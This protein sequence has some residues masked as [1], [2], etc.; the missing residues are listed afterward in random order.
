M[1]QFNDIN[2]KHWKEYGDI[3]TD[4]LWLFDKRDNSGVHS[5]G[6]H[7]N[8][9]PQIPN[10]LFRRYT[11]KGDWILDPFTG[12]GTSLI[13]AQRLGRNSLG[14][15]L[16]KDVAEKAQDLLLEEN[17]PE[18]KGKIIVGDSRTVNLHSKL[19]PFGIDKVQFIIYHPPY[20]DIVKFSDNPYDLSNAESLDVFLNSLGQ[21]IDN[22]APYLEKN[23]Y[24]AIVIGDKYS[25]GEIAPLGFYCMNLFMQRDFILKAILVKNFEETKG[26]TNQRAIWRYRALSS[27][28]Y[29][30]KH[31]YIMVFKKTTESEL[32]ISEEPSA[33][34][35]NNKKAVLFYNGLPLAFSDYTL[36]CIGSGYIALCEKADRACVLCRIL[37]EKELPFHKGACHRLITQEQNYEPKEQQVVIIK[38]DLY[39]LDEATE[40][41]KNYANVKNAYKNLTVF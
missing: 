5:A 24:C 33:K 16:Q 41:I 2:M 32:I 40:I 15:E 38:R 22:T 18:T 19:Q 10:Q 25:S 23:R 28:F 12:S 39:S 27:D 29:I 7:G 35:P 30:F 17:N 21:V 3:L 37:D 13:E 26:K 1:A 9:I 8:F 11:K 20:W 6:Y 14:I 31:E 36:Y 4:S 34:I